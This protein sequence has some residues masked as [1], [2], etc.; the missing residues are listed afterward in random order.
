MGPCI[1]DPSK[2]YT[3]PPQYSIRTRGTSQRHWPPHWASGVCL[4]N[5]CRAYYLTA[6]GVVT[7][8][9]ATRA[10]EA[11]QSRSPALPAVLWGHGGNHCIGHFSVELLL[12]GWSTY[13]W[14]LQYVSG[15]LLVGCCERQESEKRVRRCITGYVGN[16]IGANEEIMFMVSIVGGDFCRITCGWSVANAGA[17]VLCRMQI[18][19]ALLHKDS[20]FSFA[21][22]IKGSFRPW[23]FQ[24]VW[25]W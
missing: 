13:L 17:E 22:S 7:L 24:V 5:R 9:L 18:F 8:V 10:S 2:L 4:G 15:R 1:V 14:L 16:K 11:R 3:F 20:Y 21:S 12:C 25:P 23:S 19:H 6:V